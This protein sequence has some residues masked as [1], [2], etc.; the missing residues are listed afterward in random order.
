[1]SDI[2]PLLTYLREVLEPRWDPNRD[3][4]S[5]NWGRGYP[6]LWAAVLRPLTR[7]IHD[8]SLA[9]TVAHVEAW[10]RGLAGVSVAPHGSWIRRYGVVTGL[11]HRVRWLVGGAWVT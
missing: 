9:L 4:R 8:G 6:T 2:P 10:G 5:P 1:M 3:S 7:L 11:R